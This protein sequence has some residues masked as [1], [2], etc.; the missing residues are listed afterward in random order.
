MDFQE[1][2]PL[3][4]NELINLRDLSQIGILQLFQLPFITRPWG[5]THVFASSSRGDGLMVAVRL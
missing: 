3:L 4:P 2:M 5:T 1:S